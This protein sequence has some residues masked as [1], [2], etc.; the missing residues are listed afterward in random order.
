[1]KINYYKSYIDAIKWSIGSQM[2]RNFWINKWWKDIDICQNGNLSCAYYVSNLLKQFNIIDSWSANTQATINKLINKWRYEISPETDS[3]KIPVGS[4]LTRKWGFGDD[5]FHDHIWFYVWNEITISSD[6]Y[7]E[8]RSG[9]DFAEP[10]YCPISHHYTYKWTREITKIYTYDFESKIDWLFH[11]EMEINIYGQTE[12]YISDQ[13]LSNEETKRAIWKEDWLNHWR[14]CG[15]SLVLSAIN[16]YNKD[17][18]SNNIYISKRLSDLIDYRNQNYTFAHP[19][20]WENITRNIRNKENWRWHDGLVYIASKFDI[21]WSTY[22]KNM[23]DMTSSQII[24]MIYE[25]IKEDKLTILSVD[26]NIWNWEFLGKKWWHLVMILWIDYNW[27]EYSLMIW[28]PLYPKFSQRV[29]IDRFMQWF[30]GK[31][32]LLYK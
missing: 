32:M 28:N 12:E 19:E 5:W 9:L 10:Q 22:K 7:Q 11:E 31:W 6:S 30:G 14:V 17:N 23:S 3:D 4:I 16:Y 27:Y 20:T 15:L 24:Y 21:K 1:M 26:M 25:N 13:W 29:N 18:I 2:Y 8:D